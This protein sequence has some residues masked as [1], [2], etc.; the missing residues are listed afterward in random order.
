M[1]CLGC[2]ALEGGMAEYLCPA[3]RGTVGPRFSTDG[4]ISAEDEDA[5]T[6]LR[7]SDT[8][9]ELPIPFSS[10]GF[11]DLL[12]RWPPFPSLV[13]VRSFLSFTVTVN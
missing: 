7:S 1:C 8:L 2:A 4:S 9:T 11:L 13:L 3:L 10:D 5:P 12:S 6:T